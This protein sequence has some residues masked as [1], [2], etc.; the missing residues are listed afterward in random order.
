MKMY[1]LKIDLYT[2]EMQNARVITCIIHLIL[3]SINLQQVSSNMKN[4][5]AIKIEIDSSNPFIF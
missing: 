3:Y 1:I 4:V 5:V 2:V